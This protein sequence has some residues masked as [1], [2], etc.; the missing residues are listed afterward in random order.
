MIGGSVIYKKR[1]GFANFRFKDWGSIQKMGEEEKKII[2]K[3]NIFHSLK[4]M[5]SAIRSFRVE[6]NEDKSLYWVV[7]IGMIESLGEQ[8]YIY[9]FFYEDFPVLS[10]IE[11]DIS[12]HYEDQKKELNNKL[13][14]AYEENHLDAINKIKLQ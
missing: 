7:E 11:E 5:D 10:E 2:K 8:G 6:R 14:S 1:H 12:Q 3:I 13:L 9:T 4:K